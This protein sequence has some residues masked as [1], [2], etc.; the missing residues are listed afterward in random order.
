MT[1]Q[2][3]CYCLSLCKPLFKANLSNTLSISPLFPQFSASIEEKWVPED[4]DQLRGIRSL[5]GPS[6]R[7]PA[8]HKWEQC[9][10]YTPI[11]FFFKSKVDIIFD[12]SIFPPLFFS[13]P[14]FL[15]MFLFSLYLLLFHC[16]L[17]KCWCSL[18]LLSFLFSFPLTQFVGGELIHSHDIRYL[19]YYKDSQICS[20]NLDFFP[21][22]RSTYQGAQ[23]KNLFEVPQ[24]LPTQNTHD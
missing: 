13:I 22:S 21:S 15:W 6:S 14:L 5:N 7:S 19:Y 16:T 20:T 4:L 10:S 23:G 9:K 11:C 2:Q 1:V 18:D 17:F 8:S 3:E 24:I 12:D